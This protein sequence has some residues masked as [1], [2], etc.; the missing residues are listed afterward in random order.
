MDRQETEACEEVRRCQAACAKWEQQIQ[1]RAKEEQRQVSQLLAELQTAG[2]E[3]ILHWMTDTTGQAQ[4]AAARA[5]L[6]RDA[7][8][9]G[10]VREKMKAL[11][12]WGK[13]LKTANTK[14]VVQTAR[15]EMDLITEWVQAR[16][17]GALTVPAEQAEAGE[18]EC[19]MWRASSQAGSNGHHRIG[20][21]IPYKTMSALD[22]GMAGIRE[23]AAM[24]LIWGM[25][26][27]FSQ[28]T[29]ESEVG[30]E[31]GTVKWEL[32]ANPER[33]VDKRVSVATGHGST[34]DLVV[35]DFE[36]VFEREVSSYEHENTDT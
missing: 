19:V 18:V 26:R 12:E 13:L 15:T 11:E 3:R 5:R 14:T 1:E 8:K 34:F 29:Y 30:V 9:E 28:D 6:E 2:W 27:A 25:A 16:Y 31:D 36:R 23:Q 21:P 33:L 20:L 17:P 7:Q 32:R 4:A 10:E 24:Q 22:D 35:R